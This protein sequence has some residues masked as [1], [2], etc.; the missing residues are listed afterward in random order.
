MLAFIKLFIIHSI[1]LLNWLS[2]RSSRHNFFFSLGVVR[3]L[4]GFLAKKFLDGFWGE[5]CFLIATTFAK[6]SLHLCSFLSFYQLSPSFSFGPFYV[7]V[8][9][10]IK[11]IGHFLPTVCR[12]MTK[13]IKLVN[14]VILMKLSCF[15]AVTLLKGM[16]R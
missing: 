8:M 6:I 13:L 5:L 9:S 10:S 11:L 3:P 2:S 16:L 4:I 12:K 1:L 7:F 15:H 14:A